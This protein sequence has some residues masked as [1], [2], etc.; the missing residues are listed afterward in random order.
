M[1]WRVAASITPYLAACHSDAYFLVPTWDKRA[2]RWA[3]LRQPRQFLRLARVVK[4]LR[5]AERLSEGTAFLDIGAHVGTSSIIAVIH[6][7]FAKAVALE[8]DPD[9]IRL[10]RANAALN[11]V[12]GRVRAVH[13]A[14]SSAIGNAFFVPGRELGGWTSGKLV[15]EPPSPG[16]PV[17]MTTLAELAPDAA[18]DGTPVGLVWFGRPMAPWVALDSLTPFLERR[19]P[20]VM[21]LGSQ[22]EEARDYVEH[23]RRHYEHAVDIRRD[24]NTPL[25]QWVPE[26]MRA[27]EIP[28]VETMN[29]AGLLAF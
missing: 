16:T 22:P 13:G 6:H 26:T 27:E 28:H 24:P 9:S 25:D 29:R 19:V 15:E 12:D 5:D 8:P 1:F 4:I 3:Q 14:L 10:L 18:A 2:R 20:I 7:G 21:P 23:V 11:G 17:A